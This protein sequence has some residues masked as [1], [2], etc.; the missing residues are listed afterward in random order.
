[1]RKGDGTMIEVRGK[2]KCGVCGAVIEEGWY[3]PDYIEANDSK[4]FLCGTCERNIR[5]SREKLKNTYGSPAR[6]SLIR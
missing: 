4:L 2:I 1:M 5:E 6:R 3:V